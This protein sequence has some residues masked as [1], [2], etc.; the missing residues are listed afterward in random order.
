MK[1]ACF[2][3]HRPVF[4][5]M[6]ACIVVLLGVI[7]LSRLPVDLMPD[8]TYPTVSISTTYADA[9]PQEMEELVTKLV[10]DGVSAVTGV[11]QI[12]STSIEGRSDV[13]VTFTWGTDLDASTADIRDRIDRIVPRLPDDADRP[14]VR[15]FDVAAFPVL[16]CGVA[17][18]IDLLEARNIIDNQVQYRIERL[19]GVATL[20]VY[21]G[22]E[23]E[24]KVELDPDKVK[25][26]GLS[27]D[28]VLQIIKAGNVTTPAGNI[29]VGNLEVR[30]RTPGTYASIDEL[31]DAVLLYRDGAPIR[32]RDV[33]D[34]IDGKEDVTRIVRINGKPG[35][36]IGVVKQ[37]G[38]NTVRVAESVLEEIERINRDIPQL[39]IVP[40][41]DTS[42]YVR[43]AIQNVSRAA[44]FGG[45]LAL[46]VL[47]FFLRNLRSTLIIAT[48]IPLSVVASFAMIYFGGFTLNIMTL[49]GLALGVGMLVDNAIVV[50]ENITRHRDSGAGREEAAIVG[51]EEVTSAIVASTLTTVV[52]FVPLVFVRGM[53]GVMFRQLAFVIAFA[54]L[55]SLIAAIFLVPMLASKILQRSVHHDHEAGHWTDRFLHLSSR[56]FEGM[57][58]GYKDLLHFALDHRPAVIALCFSVLAGCL[59]LAPL[60]G[61]EFMPKADESQVR[62]YIEMEVGTQVEVV[63]R[64]M[65]QIDRILVAEVPEIK[66]RVG[67]CGSGGWRAR[68]SHK[69]S[70]RVNLVPVR[71][72]SRSSEQIALDLQKKLSHIPGVKVRT[73][74]GQGFFLLRMVTSGGEKIAIDVRGYDFVTANELARQVADIAEE[75]AGVTDTQLSRDLGTPEREICIDRRKAAN[76]KLSVKQIADTLRT[77]L[78]GSQ[79]GT[80]REGGDE[81]RILV[82]V[83]NAEKMAIADILDTIIINQAGEPV[84]LRNIVSSEPCTGPVSIGRKDQE[85][86]IT[87]AVNIAERDMGSIITDIREGLRGLAM[88]PG[89]GIS[90]S[91]DYEDQQ[92]AFRELLVS[93]ILAVL[94]VY[95]VMACQFESLRDPFVIMFSVPFAAI[96]VILTLFLTDTTLNVQSLIG[97]IMLAGI[98]VNNAILLVD[99][100]KVL[101]RRD[102]L[103]LRQA[104]E[105]AGRRRLR[106][107]LMTA[108]TTSLALVPLAIGLG[109]GGEAQAPMARVVIGGLLSSC[110]ITLVL[111]PIVYS[112]IESRRGVEAAALS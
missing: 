64:A 89:F 102:G 8:I 72:R 76:L 66:S 63:D 6:V 68:G 52:V 56:L 47:L 82:R 86:T 101:R 40:L 24:I 1:L 26:F 44:I 84:V 58:N 21:G 83:K 41:L 88:P 99:H 67:Y 49:G 45:F 105:E 57:E 103:D 77:I 92:E 19:P 106:P 3:V 36:Q 51:G 23:R 25:A 13:R 35:I 60:I 48:S 29:E 85:R 37:S 65:Q 11:E 107:I 104:I 53:A 20:R 15:K 96:G 90:F 39:N 28:Q 87:V 81:H 109:E 78:A 42:D 7:S 14:R 12:T 93:F 16:I 30:I 108:M 31:A 94:L 111:V 54:L 2:S 100:T 71:Q 75:V 34:V 62:V 27:L 46:L 55:C 70:F 32:V 33:A 10:E 61:T 91:G 80:Y 97:C 38:S 18:D 17:T 50:L 74:A 79:A 98:V 95:M 5:S 73:R 9:S 4:T 59:F 112:L 69:G 110:L 22:Q 43:R